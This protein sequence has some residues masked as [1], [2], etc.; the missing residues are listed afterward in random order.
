[1]GTETRHCVK[2]V[3][4]STLQVWNNRRTS[5]GRI[6]TQHETRYQ[7]SPHTNTSMWLLRIVILCSARYTLLWCL[8]RCL[9]GPFSPLSVQRCCNLPLLCVFKEVYSSRVVA[10]FV[11]AINFLYAFQ[12]TNLGTRGSTETV[13]INTRAQIRL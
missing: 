11:E 6:S 2:R 3:M 5:I 12:Y 13:G 8:I 4:G 1:M 10:G 9:A 7:V